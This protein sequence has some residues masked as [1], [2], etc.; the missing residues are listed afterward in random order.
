MII[1]LLN[2]VWQTYLKIAPYLFIGLIVAGLL[3][4]F[5]KKDFIIKHLGKNDFLSVV[6]ASVLGVPLPLSK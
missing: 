3:H 5:F 1:D 6:K 4:I 2:D